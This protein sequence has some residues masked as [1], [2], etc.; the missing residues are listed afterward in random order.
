MSIKEY[1]KYLLLLIFRP[2]SLK[3]MEW[4]M[5]KLVNQDRKMHGLS[6]LRMQEDLREVARKHSKDMAKKKY[7]SHTNTKSHSPQDRLKLARVTDVHSGENLALIQGYKNATQKAEIGLMNSPG[8]RANILNKLFNCVG[9][10]VIQSTDKTYYFTQNFAK[11]EI[12]FTKKI[13]K[14]IKLKKGL[15]IK[16]Y[17]MKKIP[18]II[19]ELKHGQIKIHKN[20]RTNKKKFKSNISFPQTGIFEIKFGI[21]TK[22][23]YEFQIV[24]HFEIKIK[25]GWW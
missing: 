4:R 22:K 21:P 2:H 16:G 3:T 19:Y 1:L 23:P 25:K 11:R 12:I 5:L 20:I 15:T 6:K 17:T 13:P 10:G 9:I 8:H 14:K 7:F 18:Y 24:N